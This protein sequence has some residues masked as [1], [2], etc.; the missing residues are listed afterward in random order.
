V[1]AHKAGFIVFVCGILGLVMAIIEQ[2]AYTDGMLLNQYLTSSSMLIG[3]QV[4]TII[5][6]LLVGCVIAA[7][8]Q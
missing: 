6:A 1:A 2:T 4:L 5:V 8:T 7:A 3:L